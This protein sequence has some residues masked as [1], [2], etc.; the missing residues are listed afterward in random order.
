MKIQSIT[1][2]NFRSYKEA[3]KVEFDDLTV[4]VGKN[5]IGKSTILEALEI[6]FYDGKDKIK[7]DINDKNK[8]SNDNE[9]IMIAVEFFS[10]PE[11]INID[12][13]NSTTLQ[14]EYLLNTNHNL[15][16]IKIFKPTNSTFKTETY[17]NALHP[18]NQYCS[19]LLLTKQ[20][21]LKK[22]IDN[23]NIECS[24]K[25]VN[26][27]MRKS[28]WG[29]YSET[30]DL[31]ETEIDTSKED[32]K[33]IYE[34]L[35]EYFPIYSLFQSDR[36]NSD[37]DEEIQDP[38][39]EAVKQILK[40]DSIQESFKTIAQ[41]VKEKLEDVSSRT[42]EKL[43]EMSPD[44]AKTLTP[45]IPSN[46]RLKWNDVFKTV[47]ITSD[48][49]IPINKRGSGVKRLILLN[50]FRAEA[51]R[52]KK[53]QNNPD[54]IYAIEEPETSQHTENQIKLIEA[55]KKLSNNV[56]II[57]TTHSANIVKNLNYENIRLIIV[58]ENIKNIS[59]INENELNYP[60][61]NEINYKAFNEVTEEYH[62]ELYGYIEFENWL[63]DFK[64]KRETREYKK[65]CKSELKI[66]NKILS[67][68]IRHQIHHP[69]NKH[70]KRFTPE[71]LE[72]SIKEMIVFIQNQ[73][74]ND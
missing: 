55:F 45:Q 16:I 56:Q 41:K 40:D 51:D 15:E 72:E 1:I 31:Q 50:F 10:L 47:S 44:V 63:N 73:K 19:N 27:D 17:I 2:Q 43:K 67:E 58:N 53:E 70:N 39:K 26:S 57:I 52:L 61:L 23:N 69:E 11:S 30:L 14:D 5:D 28:I 24:N 6:F 59:K 22:I 35:K 25:K 13:T 7:L 66:E 29:H 9:D 62:N 49:E 3:T 36:K 74:K 33:N 64:N 32:S 34:R 8:S 18:R 42:L 48:N 20:Q 54:V 37:G 4:F 60:S 65:Q 12:A 38:L 46:D 21:D 68:Y 71:E